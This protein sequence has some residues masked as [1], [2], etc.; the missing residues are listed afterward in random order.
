MRTLD[1][2]CPQGWT[3]WE[4]VIK[5]V[6]ESFKEL[7]IETNQRFVDYGE[8]DKDLRFGKFDLLMKT[9]TADLS[10]ATPWTRFNQVMSGKDAKPVGEEA[11]SNQGRFSDPSADSLLNLIPSLTDTATLNPIDMIVMTIV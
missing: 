1:L 5:I 7:G 9:Q 10:A 8:W 2:E 6:A 4:D 3:D 11:Y